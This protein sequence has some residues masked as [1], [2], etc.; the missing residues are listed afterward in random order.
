M[1]EMLTKLSARTM[2]SPCKYCGTK[3]LY[4]ARN[5]SGKTVVV[6]ADGRRQLPVGSKFLGE[7]HYL[8]CPKR[9]QQQ[10]TEATDNSKTAVEPITETTSADPRMAALEALFAGP[11]EAD[12]RRWIGEGLAKMDRPERIIVRDASGS[13][14]IKLEGH[15]HA[16]QS[17]VIRL[18]QRGLQPMLVGPA[19]TGKSKLSEI[20][21]Q[22]LGLEYYFIS[23]TPTPMVEVDIFGFMGPEGYVP[24]DVYSAVKDGGLVL[25][26]EADKCHPGVFAKCNALL[27]AKPGDMV[28]FP[29]GMVEVHENF[30]AMIAANTYATGPDST[31]VG[32][33]KLDGATIDRFTTVYV[34]Y[35]ES[36]E[37]HLCRATGAKE[38]HIQAILSVVRHGRREAAKRGLAVI[39]G[40]RSSLI[41]CSLVAGDDPFAADEVVEMGIRRGISTTDWESLS[42]PKLVL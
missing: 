12:V 37:T 34:D 32:S 36:L 39:L 3:D 13:N 14:E 24:T 25:F 8:T 27:A 9:Q 17:V 21:A 29:C 41:A 18:L 15:N 31:Y 26:D 35:D 23:C 40:M 38:D 2:R 11:N 16:K 4:A 5:E 19:G 7:A 10:T 20:A 28:K 30:K 42:M 33:N 1:Q 6:D 22:A